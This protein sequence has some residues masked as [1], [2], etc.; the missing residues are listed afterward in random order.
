M[1]KKITLLITIAFFISCVEDESLN[2]NNN[3]S[4]EISS[5]VIDNNTETGIKTTTNLNIT[6]FDGFSFQNHGVV[7]LHKDSTV[8]TISQGALTKNSFESV[9]NSGI[10]KGNAYSV[11]PYVMAENQFVYGD[12][13]DFISR[14]DIK[15]KVNEIRPLNGF[16][17]DTISIIG[18][19]FCKSLS[20][21]RTQFLLNNNYQNVIFESDSL[22]KAVIT[23]YI[24][25]SKLTPTVRNCGVD[26]IMPDVFKINPPKLDSLSSAEA[27]V[28]DNAFIYGENFHSQISHVWI[29]DI[30]A[31]L[32]KERLDIDKLEFTVPEGLPEDLLNL[33]I[34][35]LDT[36]I[37]KQGYYKS[38]SPVIKSLD[39]RDTGFLDTLTI[40]GD[41]LKQKNVTT[42][43]FVGGR[44]QKILSVSNEEIQFVISEYFSEESSKLL[45]KLGSFE[46][47]EDL[48]MLPPEIV[49]FDKSKYHLYDDF[50]TFKTKYF[51]AN[52]S[53]NISIGGV[54]LKSSSYRFEDVDEKGNVTLSISDWLEAQVYRYP[55]FIFAETGQLKVEIKTQFGTSEKNINIFPPKIESIANNSLFISS[56]TDY[57]ELSGLDFGYK[58]VSKVYID[59]EVVVDPYTSAYNLFNTQIN[60]QIPSNVKAGDHKL[61]VETGGQFSNE[62]AFN[63]KEITATGISN[64]SG[65]REID[66]FTITGNNLENKYSYVIKVNGIRC[67]VVNASK[68]QVEFTIPYYTALES[69]MPVTIEYGD[70]V[71]DV[72]IIDGFEPHAKLT[73]YKDQGYNYLAHSSSHFEYNNKLYFISD[74]G[75]FLFDIDSESWIKVESNMPFSNYLDSNGKNYIS[76]VG[77]KIYIPLGKTFYPYDMVKKTWETPIQLSLE[78][79]NRMVY[80]IV[81]DESTAYIIEGLSLK[82]NTTFV[83]YDLENHTKQT[84]TQPSYT[85]GASGLGDELYYHNGKVYLDGRDVNINVYDIKTDQWEDIGFPTN[86]KYFYDNNLYVYKN[87]LY[88]SGGQGNEGLQYNLYGYD[89]STK[90]WTE[91]TPLLLK[92]GKHAVWGNEDFLYFGLGA[93]TY[94]SYEN[95]EMIKYDIKK[96][97]R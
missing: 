72:G 25:A 80:G 48:N 9:I 58:G 65:A 34:K 32:N 83:K 22:I 56:S 7:I 62:I 88:F 40:K 55:S 43:V 33:K 69:N 53:S 13:L 39:K 14:L 76:Q 60:F 92:L 46:L 28:G 11:F 96:D 2:E 86:Y 63:V 38:T 64:S 50:V 18:E 85:M 68:T 94:V 47:E 82:S 29:N 23:P 77:D 87:V 54:T 26:T 74:T 91:K 35:V 41:Y 93:Q 73:N 37:E 44:E 61:K 78:E 57:I 12:T 95:R 51:I 5:F 20:D 10:V 71:I 67:T 84:L 52:S 59:D 49:S 97:N 3:K 6:G 19:N 31:S 66:L 1:I 21:T 45:L 81:T 27:Y 79:G 90:V 16:V 8:R 30:E 4:V 70:A 89:L 24:D 36:V 15:I 17:Y 75:I 42:K